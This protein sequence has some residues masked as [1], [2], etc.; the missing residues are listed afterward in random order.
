MCYPRLDNNNNLEFVYRVQE[1]K[2]VGSDTN[3]IENFEW[4]GV[5]KYSG[6]TNTPST[7]ITPIIV[8]DKCRI[9]IRAKADTG[10]EGKAIGYFKGYLVDEKA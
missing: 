8:K 7:V 6:S 10:A 3:Y 4:A 1:P 9:R 2:V 5:Y